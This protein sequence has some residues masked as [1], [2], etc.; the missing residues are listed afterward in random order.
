MAI[1]FDTGGIISFATT[2]Y[3]D[4]DE[5][6]IC[7]WLYKNSIVADSEPPKSIKYG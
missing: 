7:L 6:L 3:E 4:Y 1:G 2:T 5:T